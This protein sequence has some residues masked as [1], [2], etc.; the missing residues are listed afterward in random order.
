MNIYRQVNAYKAAA[1][2]TATPGQLLIML[3]DG[4]IK[5]LRIAI[6]GFEHTDPLEYN[7]TIHN[8]VVKA[9]AIVRE[10]RGALMPR[11]GM[12]LSELANT[13]LAL[14]DYFDRRLQE[15]NMKKNRVA[16]QEVLDRLC[17]LRGAWG[18]SFD[19]ENA[20]KSSSTQSA[21]DNTPRLSVMG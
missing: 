2:T 11:E 15:G 13:L 3:Y 14:Y 5:F 19:K 1:V 9:Q 4:A 6:K 17:E 7:L 12:E 8:N 18:D 10:L 20:K 21:G 16:V